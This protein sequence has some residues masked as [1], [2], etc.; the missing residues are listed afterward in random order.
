MKGMSVTPQELWGEQK[1]YVAYMKSFGCKVCCPTDKKE[2]GGKLGDVRYEGMLVGYTKDN[3][4][5]RLWNSWKDKRVLNM[6]GA[7]YEEAVERGWWLERR[8]RRNL[9]EMETR[10]L[11][12]RI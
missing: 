2:R 10:G 8:G 12:S 3:P 7:D 11:P 6:G 5:V 1:L 4:S 9:E